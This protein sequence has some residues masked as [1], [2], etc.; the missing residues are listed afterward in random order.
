MHSVVRSVGWK[1]AARH[2]VGPI[3]GGIS[4]RVADGVRC[5][6]EQSGLRLQSTVTEG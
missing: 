1:L 3:R 5:R 2:N 4:R 6:T